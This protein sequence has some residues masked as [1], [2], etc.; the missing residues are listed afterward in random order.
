MNAPVR[1]VSTLYHMALHPTPYV[2][3]T[4]YFFLSTLPGAILVA[5]LWY[6]VALNV[7]EWRERRQIVLFRWIPLRAVADVALIAAG[8]LLA[9]G[10]LESFRPGAQ[11]FQNGCYGPLTPP[12]YILSAISLLVWCVAFLYFPARD[13]LR[14]RRTRTE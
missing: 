3:S 11:W 7:T 10:A 1:I 8:C 14:L 13:L 6:W 9:A 4:L 2:G 12:F 5:L